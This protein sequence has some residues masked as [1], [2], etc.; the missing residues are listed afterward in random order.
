MSKVKSS[1]ASRT[2]ALSYQELSEQLD[3]A[4]AKLQD[5]TKGVDDAIQCYETALGL[6]EKLETYLKT[7]ENRVRELQAGMDKKT[8]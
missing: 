6:I 8:T 2:P 4:M 3:E 5:P 1:D 7:A